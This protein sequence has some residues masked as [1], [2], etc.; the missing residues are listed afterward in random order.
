VSVLSQATLS[1]VVPMYEVDGII[2]DDFD[3]V[4][5]H[6]QGIRELGAFRTRHR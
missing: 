2:E 6:G 4:K 5:I 3:Q 1:V